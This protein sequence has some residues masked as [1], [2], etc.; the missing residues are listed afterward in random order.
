MIKILLLILLLA[1][2]NVYGQFYVCEDD[3]KDSRI[4]M[5]DMELPTIPIH[6]VNWDQAMTNN[7][8]GLSNG[9]CWMLTFATIYTTKKS[10]KQTGKETTL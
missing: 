8:V 5:N 4:S 9:L 6:E 7:Y 3:F 1:A 2:I 10:H